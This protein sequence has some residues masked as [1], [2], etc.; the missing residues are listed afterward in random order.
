MRNL[1]VTT[2]AALLALTALP[3]IAHH[4]A[5]GTVDEEIYAMIDD[6]VADTPHGDLV[7]EDLGGGMT[8]IDIT[9]R[10]PDM[11]SLVADGL[12]DYVAMLDGDV[13]MTI[14]FTDQ[15]DL[16]VR[17]LQ[18]EVPETG[19]ADKAVTDGEPVSFG[20]VKAGYR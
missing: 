8:G 10:V 18:V 2:V 13:V 16:T 4:M 7:L 12:L 15:R 6:M 1:I 17:I 20:S 9:T 19:D 11:E 5:E 3:V 14:D